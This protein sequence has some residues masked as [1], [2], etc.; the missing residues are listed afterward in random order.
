MVYMVEETPKIEERN[1]KIEEKKQQR[2]IWW[3]K[4]DIRLHDNLALH[5]ALQCS[6]EVAQCSCE[7]LPV[8]IVEP[9][10]IA[11][12]DFS[13]MHFFAQFTAIE[14]LRKNL[15]SLGGDLLVLHGKAESELTKLFKKWPF[16]VICSHQ[17]TGNWLTYQRD[18]A[19]QGFC[20]TANITWREQHQN[21]SIRRLSGRVNRQ[22]IIRQRLFRE[23]VKAPTSKQGMNAICAVN[24]VKAPKD[25]VSLSSELNQSWPHASEYFSATNMQHIQ[26]DKLQIVNETSALQCLDSF[27][28]ERGRGYSGGISSPNS[29]FHNGSRLS[30]H[31]A[32]GTLSL[33]HV[34]SKTT[35]RINELKKSEHA[36]NKQWRRSLHAFSSRLHWHCHFIQ[37]LES[38]PRMEFQPLNPAYRCIRYE[39]DAALFSAWKSGM[40]GFPLVDAC[41]RCLNAIGFVNFR[42]RAF[43]VSFAIFGLHLDWRTIHPHLAQVFYDYE[44][45]IHLAQL[46]MQAGIVGINTIRVYSPTKQLIEQD[47]DCQ[48]VKRWLP[49]LRKSNIADIYS[50]ESIPL[51]D[52]PSPVVDFKLRAKHMKE[53]IFAVRKSQAGRSESA[54]VLKKHGSRKKV[55]TK[56]TKQQSPQISLF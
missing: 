6:C 42:M 37:R 8:F 56:K 47:R 34:F 18:I 13:A 53:Q 54:L 9:D 27:L 49:E 33:C 15:Q 22:P 21:G 36:S 41:M 19:V 10:I 5:D 55:S 3:V 46:Q 35:E 2:T 48:F 38:E 7:V 43:V 4:R 45:G 44:P 1:P 28:F 23:P 29:A 50:Y 52:Y 24:I 25:M 20:D 30:V 39:D 26:F 31:L 17:E 14:E 12:D 16:G 11:A 40:T 32:W 51:D